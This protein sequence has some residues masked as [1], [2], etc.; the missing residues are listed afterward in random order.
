[1][2]VRPTILYQNPISII[3]VQEGY[4]TTLVAGGSMTGDWNTAAIYRLSAS[5]STS[6]F[7]IRINNLPTTANKAYT[8]TTIIPQSATQAGYGA[9]LQIGGVT[10]TIYWQ[11]NSTP[12]GTTGIA[13]TDV[14][15]LTLL[16]SGTTWTA[17][18]NYASYGA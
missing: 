18:G 8:F 12:A 5:P 9:T 16:Y 1:M 7:T 13:K 10:T 11:N 4:A 6:T 3:G 14:E 15:T 2:S 17:L